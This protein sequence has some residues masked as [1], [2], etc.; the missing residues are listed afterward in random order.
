MRRSAAVILLALVALF[1][2]A[3]ANC[4]N[5]FTYEGF[6]V[7]PVGEIYLQVPIV[8]GV[9]CVKCV[10]S[11]CPPPCVAPTCAPVCG[12][13]LRPS[14]VVEHVGTVSCA[15]VAETVSVCPAVY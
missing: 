5:G 2:S 13:V 10:T 4:Y 9:P 14:A 15:G 8:G 6:T 1:R 7:T 12:V 11:S 3:E